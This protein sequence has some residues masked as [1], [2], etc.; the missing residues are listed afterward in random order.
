METGPTK[1][2]CPAQLA[3]KPW[4]PQSVQSLHPPPSQ[5]QAGFRAEGHKPQALKPF[6]LLCLLLPHPDRHPYTYSFCLKGLLSLLRSEERR[7]GKECLRLCRS[8][9]SPYH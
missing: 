9:W 1:D 8:R 6:P 4:G 5:S 2:Y 7:V 3:A